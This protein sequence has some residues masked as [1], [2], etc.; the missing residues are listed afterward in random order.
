[1]PRAPIHQGAPDRS[2]EVARSSLLSLHDVLPFIVSRM[3]IPRLR[4]HDD[5]AGDATE[6]PH[7]QSCVAPRT[8]LQGRC[9]VVIVRRLALP[10]R[11]GARSRDIVLFESIDQRPERHPELLRGACLVSGALLQRLDDLLAVRGLLTRP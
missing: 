2:G 7:V 1:M 9:V 3:Q 10:F 5:T 6:C 11:A 4:D 8:T